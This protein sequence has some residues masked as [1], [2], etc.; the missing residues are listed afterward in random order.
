MSSMIEAI[1]NPD[2]TREQAIAIGESGWW[3]LYPARDVALAQLRQPFLCM[4]F[5]DFHR[6][7]EDAIGGPVWTHEFARPA[8]LIEGGQRGP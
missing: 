3:K 8:S 7:V 5:G 6:I 1:A 4:P 2:M